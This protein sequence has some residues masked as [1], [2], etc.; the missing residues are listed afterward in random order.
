[1]TG[2]PPWRDLHRT[3]DFR[4]AATLTTCLAAMEFD[5]TLVDGLGREVSPEIV[6]DL[7]EPFSVRVPVE[8]AEM[9]REVLKEIIEEQAQ[10]DAA[11][12]LRHDRDD[13]RHR[14]ALL[15]LIAVVA[16]LAALGVIEL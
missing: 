4:E 2:D 10:F 14:H 5:A 13:R 11:L 12:A 7:K 6:D 3:R 16:S 9:L 8:D 1:M 15:V